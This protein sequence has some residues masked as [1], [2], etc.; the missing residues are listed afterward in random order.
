MTSAEATTEDIKVLL[1]AYLA[2]PEQ[3]NEL[4]SHLSDEQLDAVPVPG[5]WSIRQVIS[6]IA[7]FEIVAADR[8]RRVLAEDNPVMADGDPDRFVSAL[9][10]GAR[11]V[12]EELA[13]IDTIRRST[14][15]MLSACD[16]EDLQRTGVHS[17][18]GPMTL[19][20]LLERC[21]NHIPHHVTFLCEKL[22]VLSDGGLQQSE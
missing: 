18:E 14:A 15:R 22:A 21:T 16:V 17:A 10:Y 8:I 7:D 20:T 2:G 5:K 1:T 6:H 19:E 4:V 9:Q 12:K 13:M 3:L 11:D